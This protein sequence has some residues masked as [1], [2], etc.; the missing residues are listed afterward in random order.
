MDEWDCSKH[1]YD[2]LQDTTAEMS[3]QTAALQALGGMTGTTGS[4]CKSHSL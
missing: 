1:K 3:M 4:T 2:L